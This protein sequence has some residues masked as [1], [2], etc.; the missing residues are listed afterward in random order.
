[1]QLK[2]RCFD[3]RKK[4]SMLSKTH[5]GQLPDVTLVAR[6]IGSEYGIWQLPESDGVKTLTLPQ[7][8]VPQWENG[9]GK[10]VD[11]QC[12]SLFVQVL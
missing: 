3:G 12:T 7:F 5:A 2:M 10:S 4:A 11:D 8:A 6:C 1:M 9:S